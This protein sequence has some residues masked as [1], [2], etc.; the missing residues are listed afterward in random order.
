M[1]VFVSDG[2][3]PSSVYVLYCRFRQGRSSSDYAVSFDLCMSSSV[4]SENCDV[5]FGL[6]MSLLPTGKPFIRLVGFF[7]LMSS[8]RTGKAFVRLMFCIVG[9]LRMSSFL[10]GKTFIRLIDASYCGL[11]TYV[12]V[13][14]RKD[15]HQTD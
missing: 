4:P 13:S 1:Y 3:R 15:L 9:Y 6:C 2:K 10:T 12:F 11:L 8:F 5:C 7:L 14:D